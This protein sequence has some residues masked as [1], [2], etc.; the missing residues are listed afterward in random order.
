MAK[1]TEDQLQELQ[2]QVFSLTK[3]VAKGKEKLSEAEKLADA[4]SAGASFMGNTSEEFPTGKTEMV[5]KCVNPYERNEKK[6]KFIDV[7]MPTYKYTIV[8][9]VGAGLFLSTNGVEYYHGQ[10]Y[11]FNSEILAE[12]K[13]RV[14]QCWSHEKSINGSNEN[15]YR[16][17]TNR[18]V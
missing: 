10:T 8:L 15:A 9:P 11:E 1:T 16:K 13:Y 17:P 7:E 3:E 18:L 5:E 6:Q 4:M 14:A 2:A 12:M